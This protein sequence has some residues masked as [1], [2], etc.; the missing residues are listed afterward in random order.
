MRSAYYVYRPT[1]KSIVTLCISE[2][3][4]YITDIMKGNEVH[5]D[6]IDGATE[7]ADILSQNSRG[8]WV[9]AKM[10]KDVTINGVE[11][12]LY[13]I[14]DFFGGGVIYDIKFKENIGNYNVGHYFDNT[15]H[16]MYFELIHGSETFVY[17]IS[18]GKKVYKEEYKRHECR[19]K[20]TYTIYNIIYY[21]TYRIIYKIICV[22]RLIDRIFRCRLFW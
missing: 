21:F 15:Q 6:W 9:Q 13:G 19:P 11:Y 22:I 16:R 12:L 7:I 4:V 18:N 10:K 5:H 1:S 17:F 2:V 8:Y 3:Q 20:V 14:P